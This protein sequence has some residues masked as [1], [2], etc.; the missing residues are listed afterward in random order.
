MLVPLRVAVAVL[1]V[2]PTLRTSTPGAKMSTPAPKLENEA[3][4]SVRA[5]I[6]PTVMA[7][8][9]DAGESAAAFTCSPLV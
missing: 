7:L 2:I 9:A 6:A 1:L 4:A 8:G 3:F 5:S